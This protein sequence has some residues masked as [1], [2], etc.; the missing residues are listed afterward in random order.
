M[1]TRPGVNGGLLRR[2]NA[3]HPPVNYI[4]VE[5]ID[6][7]AKKAKRSRHGGHAED[8]GEGDRLRVR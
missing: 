7:Y 4:A 6:E 1:P 8:G 2:R 3:G 5:S